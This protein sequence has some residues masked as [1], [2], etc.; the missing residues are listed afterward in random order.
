[1]KCNS[2]KDTFHNKHDQAFILKN[3]RCPNCESDSFYKPKPK[4]IILTCYE[5]NRE[6][7]VKVKIRKAYRKPTC[8][9][10]KK[11]KKQ[12]KADEK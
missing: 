11:L 10:C 9:N 2:C 3:G 7:I 4:T 1:M 12:Q 6:M 5:C 8:V